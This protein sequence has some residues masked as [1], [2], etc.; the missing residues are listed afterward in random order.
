MLPSLKTSNSIWF[1]ECMVC[2]GGRMPDA[3]ANVRVIKSGF[4]REE[5]GKKVMGGGSLNNRTQIAS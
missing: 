3:A 5:A 4:F 2:E 1:Q